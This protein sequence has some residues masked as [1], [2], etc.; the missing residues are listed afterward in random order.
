MSAQLVVLFVLCV[1]AG[2][3]FAR[4]YIVRAPNKLSDDDMKAAQKIAGTLDPNTAEPLSNEDFE[5]MKDDVL[6]IHGPANSPYLKTPE[7]EI[8]GGDLQYGTDKYNYTGTVANGGEMSNADYYWNWPSPPNYDSDGYATT[9]PRNMFSR[10]YNVYP[11]FNT[12][13][14]GWEVRPNI[15]NKQRQGGKW[16]QNNGSYYYIAYS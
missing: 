2:Y 3:L 5:M 14:T 6:I 1:L 10:W 13:G 4:M 9:W 8:A 16:Y 11:S 15:V 7:M 12:G